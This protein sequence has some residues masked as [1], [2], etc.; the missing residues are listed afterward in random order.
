MRYHKEIKL[1]CKSYI[2]KFTSKGIQPRELKNDLIFKNKLIKS[3]RALKKKLGYVVHLCMLT[4]ML[5]L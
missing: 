1:F 5:F 3:L 4:N 2:Y